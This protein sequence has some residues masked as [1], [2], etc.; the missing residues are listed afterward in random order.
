MFGD[1]AWWLQTLGAILSLWGALALS[2]NLFRYVP[3]KEILLFLGSCLI[4]GKF[5]RGVAE[6]G[7]GETGNVGVLQGLAFVALGIALQIAGLILDK[8]G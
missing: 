5:A 2:H 6:A 4:R 8:F 1:L 7:Y 3:W